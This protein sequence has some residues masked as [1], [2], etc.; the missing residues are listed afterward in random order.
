[1]GSYCVSELDRTGWIRRSI[2]QEAACLTFVRG[3][4][5]NRVAEAFGGVAGFGRL[6]D[7][8]EF[9]EE[10]FVHQEKHPM[11]AL[12]QLGD[13]VL[14]VEDS[15][16][17][18]QRP[19]VLRR[20]A[21]FAAVSVFWDAC[22]LTR[23]SYAVDGDVRTSFE[24]VLPEY[25]EGAEPDGLEAVRAGLPWSQADPVM[26]MLALAGRL[27]GLPPNPGWLAG[28]FH[29]FPVAPW[30]D[31]LVA[32]PNPLDNVVGY[33]IELITALRTAAEHVRRRA[34]AAA[35]R[36]VLAIADCL[37]HPVVRRTLSSMTSGFSIDRS[38]L[39]A[40][41]RE[42]TWQSTRHRR[43]SKVRDQ[44]RA[45]EVLRQA[46]HEDSLT[47][48]VNVLVG[49]RHVRGVDTGELAR[50]VATALAS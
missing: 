46:T 45:V 37:D 1:M 25:R 27:T 9:C 22:A 26:L 18:G 48:L 42:W 50:V 39:G 34:A 13:W 35:A 47:A 32:V 12:R 24:A 5:L 3:D 11:I 40:V 14:V 41:V 10:A 23:F 4:D 43:S 44:L 29:T 2:I 16:R 19:E 30:P 31:D 7:I 17:Q 20:A 21:R 15:G 6:L 8:G 28:D 49:A 36:Y 33:P 38:V